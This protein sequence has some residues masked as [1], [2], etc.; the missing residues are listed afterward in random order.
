MLIFVD[1]YVI[2]AVLFPPPPPVSLNTSSVCVHLV[3]LASSLL[4]VVE[5]VL[6]DVLPLAVV[7]RHMV[8]AL[9]QALVPPPAGVEKQ[10]QHQHWG[11]PESRLTQQG[12][13]GGRAGGRGEGGTAHIITIEM[14]SRKTY[15]WVWMKSTTWVESDE[16]TRLCRMNICMC[17]VVRVFP[18]DATQR[19]HVTVDK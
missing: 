18:S 1:L 17:C 4:V 5:H 9:L 14:L 10:A 11:V 7:R 12:A 2:C 15:L 3:L 13:R 19:A 8:H 16:T 6:P